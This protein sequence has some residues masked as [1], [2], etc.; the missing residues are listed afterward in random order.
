MARSPVTREDEHGAVGSTGCEIARY[1]VEF[2]GINGDCTLRIGCLDGLL[3]VSTSR[4]TLQ[5]SSNLR[6]EIFEALL[7]SLPRGTHVGMRVRMKT[8]P[9]DHKARRSSQS[10]ML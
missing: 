3:A 1:A 5:S 7:V 4:L 10:A 9:D 8:Y 2:E 6:A